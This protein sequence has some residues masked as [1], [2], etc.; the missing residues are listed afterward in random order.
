[1]LKMN[2]LIEWASNI[3]CYSKEVKRAIWSLI[4]CMQMSAV[5]MTRW[6]S[7]L[8]GSISK[9]REPHEE[10]TFNYCYVI[11]INKYRFL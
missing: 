6:R 11:I 5:V 1:M 3:V 2:D 4:I 10:D 7:R 8:K 9:Q